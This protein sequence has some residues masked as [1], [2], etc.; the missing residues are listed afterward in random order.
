MSYGQNFWGRFCECEVVYKAE[1]EAGTMFQCF[2]G[3]VCG[4]DWFHDTCIMGKG[5]PGYHKKEGGG[6]KPEDGAKAED[7]GVKQKLEGAANE[8]PVEEDSTQEKA[9]QLTA[10]T[11]STEPAGRVEVE[12]APALQE[13]EAD[14][15]DEQDTCEGFPKE[16]FEHFICWRCVEANPWLK[17]YAGTPGFLPGVSRQPQQPEAASEVPAAAPP[18][19]KPSTE[20]P[21]APEQSTKRKAETEASPPP[22]KRTK[23]PDIANA[24]SSAAEADTT[25]IKEE[26]PVTTT[27]PPAPVCKL[28]PASPSND[29]IS[30]FLLAPFRADLCRCPACFP[31]LS[32][33][34]C[35]L[36]E[37]ETYSPPADSETASESGSLFDRGE[38]A[39]GNMDRVKAIQGVTA[40]NALKDNLKGFLKGF[41]ESGKAVSAEDVKAHF[42]ALRGETGTVVEKVDSKGV[43]G[44]GRKEGEGY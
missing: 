30:L 40:F 29:P 25:I 9:A 16:D 44:D 27:T 41:A 31:L 24:L 33:H 15:D 10:E 4:E 19:A 18:T 39:L 35:L 1:L 5:P 43:E 2:L 17:R 3:D 37:E 26:A 14:D 34:R 11:K 22:L 23:T 42:A 28:P 12:V 7:E 13:T 32:R 21:S 6:E 36:E 8:G 38:K 20:L